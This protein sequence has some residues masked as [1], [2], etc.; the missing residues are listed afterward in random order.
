VV[1]LLVVTKRT[2][3]GLPGWKNPVVSSSHHHDSADL[4]PPRTVEVADDVFAYIQPDGS[5][6]INNT[7]FV[8][9]GDGVVSIDTCS[10]ERR[11]RA[12]LEAIRAVTDRPVRCL[13]NTHHHGDHTHGNYLFRPAP[14]IG[15]EQCRVMVK[16]FGHPNFGGVFTPMDFGELEIE[17][18]MVTFTD[19]LDL[20]AGE[21]RIEL[22]FIGGPAHTTNDVV[23]WIPERS[24]LFAGDLVFNGG[25]PFVV[26]GSVSGSLTAL[27]QVESFNA[28]VIVPGHGDPCGGEVLA[29]LRTYLEFVQETAAKGKAAGLSPLELARET[30]LDGFGHLLDPERIVGNLH[31]AYAELDG[32]APGAD[33]DI[34]AA[35]MDMVTYNGGPLR[36]LA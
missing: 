30:D 9:G 12:F 17:P 23:A 16:A 27:Q 32:A 36:C 35:I 2:P 8:V 33:I 22:H 34:M 3:A 24:V 21:L 15:H 25:T 6:W 11:S 29:G 7:G 26:M 18:P 31:R 13:V 10:T 4:P 19:R 1:F 20:W 28:D 14:V 5:W